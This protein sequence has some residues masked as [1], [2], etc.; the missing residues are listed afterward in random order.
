MVWVLLGLP[1]A[2][3]AAKADEAAALF[4][5]NPIPRISVEIAKK[6]LD[7]LREYA[8]RGTGS[9][10]NR[11]SVP[12]TVRE[13]GV[14]YTNVMVHLKGAA[15]SF[16]SVDEKPGLTLD[17]ND[18]AKGQ[19]FHGLAK[20]SL[21]NSVQ[22]PTYI[23][24]KLCRELYTQAGVGLPRC[25]YALVELNGR[26]LGLYVL[27]EGWDK[28]LA[29]R[30]YKA[31]IG[32]FYGPS[33]AGDLNKLKV[34]GSGKESTNLTYF[35]SIM[36][37]ATN[38]DVAQRVTLLRPLV[39]L[40]RFTTMLALDAMLWNWD[41][42]GM[43]KNNYRVYL[44]PGPGRL[45]FMPTGMDQMFGK[46]EGSLITGRNGIVARGLLQSPEGRRMM[47]ERCHQLYPG[48]LNASALTNR[49]LALAARIQPAL[50]ACSPGEAAVYP[51]RVRDLYRRVGA[52]CQSIESQLAGLDKAPQIAEGQT[53]ALEGYEWKPVAVSGQPVMDK[54][55]DNSLHLAVQGK[56]WGKWRTVVWLEEGTYT[57]S[58]RVKTAGVKAGNWPNPGAYIRP[59][60]LR[61]MTTG[62]HWSWFPYHESNDYELRGELA[63]ENFRQTRLLATKDW[64]ELTYEIELRQPLA[65]LEIRFELAAD[66]GEAWLDP[67]SVRLTRHTTICP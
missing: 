6:Y 47:I 15:G 18:K 62:T 14:V 56:A 20:I 12:A 7:I 66:A 64:T 43:N 31:P 39:D 32:E 36:L 65:D 34:G 63:P 52:R 55:A 21:N 25:D 27:S 5:T 50:A 24:D 61:K 35:Q 46:V 59:F 48:L 44:E 41:G 54:A 9:E 16:R 33:G 38:A 30:L 23:T 11:E 4:S 53:I 51:R 22:D 42:Y 37:A 19:R 57:L 8:W 10:T 45:V 29:K 67:Q 13:N 49:I 60:S 28:Q 1:L 58:A 2:A 26:L 40:E 17:F 3:R